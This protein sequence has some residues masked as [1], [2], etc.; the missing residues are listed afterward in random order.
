MAAERA[1]LVDSIRVFSSASSPPI[2]TRCRA[3]LSSGSSLAYGVDGTFHFGGQTYAS[4]SISQSLS[5]GRGNLASTAGVVSFERRSR[6]GFSHS[7]SLGWTGSDYD[8]GVGFVDRRGIA[9]YNGA[10]DYLWILGRDNALYRHGPGVEVLGISRIDGG[11]ESVE[12]APA[13]QIRWKSGVNVDLEANGHYEDVAE[14]FVLG[15][16]TIPRGQYSFGFAG[17]LR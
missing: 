12:I 1:R 10:V 5:G 4:G 6:R 13:W 11:L 16:A 14:P 3:S 2:A 7:Q 17:G 9:R 15:D 8:P